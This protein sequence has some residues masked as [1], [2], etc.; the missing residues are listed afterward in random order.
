MLTVQEI[1]TQILGNNPGKLYI[2]G[3]SEYGIK[4]KYIEMI[5]KHY[6]QPIIEAPTVNEILN[7]MGKKHI[8]PLTPCVY[9]VRYDESFV[10]TLSEAVAQKIKALNIVGTVV[11]LYE[12]SKH[13]TKIDKFL[14]EYVATIDAVSPQFVTKYLHSDFP[15]LADNFI[16]V[17]VD[18]SANY[19]Q[20]KNMCRCMSMVPPA[21]LAKLSDAELRK[22]FGCFDTSTEAQIRIG[23]ASR[24]FKHL[25]DVSAKYDDSPDRILYAVL[26][27]MVEIDKV[28]DNSHLQSDVKQFVKLWTREDVYYMFM[29][30]YDELIKLRSVS[31][32][33]VQN[34]L[35][36]L[37]GLLKFQRIP[38]PEVMK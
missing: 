36:Y 32:Y 37:F 34:S 13:I 22:M 2:F 15:H 10:S 11:C 7:M 25:L 35:I 21:Q 33:D 14:P 17:A 6:N 5:A 20:A 19:S 16:K 28:M 31:G 38:S 24:N 9:V 8:V 3:G 30:T 23:V 12:Q 1:G 4:E 18:A 29:N 26:S 27:T